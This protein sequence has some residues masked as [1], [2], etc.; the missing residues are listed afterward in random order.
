M[1]YQ[2]N[3]QDPRVLR[4][5]RHAYGFAR[6]VLS[7][8]PHRWST[9]YIDR[10]FGQQQT[11]LSKWLRQ[12]LLI[13]TSPTYSDSQGVCKEYRLNTTGAARI[14]DQL[15]SPT[16]DFTAEPPQTASDIQEFLHAQANE[17]YDRQVISKFIEAEWGDE[18]RTRQFTYEDKSH[19][20]WHPLQNVRKEH[21]QRAFADYNLSYQYD[22]QTCAAQLIHQHAQQQQE[23]MD[24]YLF[25]LRRYLK[26]KRTVRQELAEALDIDPKTAKVL[27]NALF[28]QA[29]IGHGG[30]F[31]VSEL[32]DHDA[33]RIAWLKQDPYIQELKSDIKTCWD[34]IQPSMMRRSQPDKRGRQRLLPITSKE[35]WMRYFDLERR[36]L[37]QVRVYLDQTANP[38][39]LE[40]DGWSCEREI[41]VNE[42]SDFIY[43]RTGFD[44]QFEQVRTFTSQRRRQLM[45]ELVE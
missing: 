23:P 39:F 1:T 34:Y 45:A 4:R 6:A 20:L 40:H 12:Q 21:K 17:Q 28:C 19:R 25:A 35:R 5:I 43:V 27:I 33:A 11:D 37:N 32:L 14:R 41:D 36:V 10:Y 31:A 24:L 2:P 3:F 18:L 26:E 13:C 15:I 22:I 29:R 9:R 16:A 7:E 30:Y 42:L 44:L 8:R 38:C